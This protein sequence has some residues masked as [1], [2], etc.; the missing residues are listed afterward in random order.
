MRDAFAI[1][2]RNDGC[3]DAF[4]LPRLGIPAIWIPAIPAGMTVF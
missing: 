2:E 1:V 3:L 4:N